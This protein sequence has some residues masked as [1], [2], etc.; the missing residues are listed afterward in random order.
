MIAGY[1]REE[2][3]I[4]N[5]LLGSDMN[6]NAKVHWGSCNVVFG[7]LYLILSITTD[8]LV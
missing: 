1:G 7:V 2:N 6:V 3:I 4:S 8:K 5:V